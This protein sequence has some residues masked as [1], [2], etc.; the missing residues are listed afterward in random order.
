MLL[1]ETLLCLLLM[2]SHSQSK[3][4]R[5]FREFIT[6]NE[7]V[8]FKFNLREKTTTSN[9]WG[10]NWRWL[11]PWHNNDIHSHFPN[12]T[13]YKTKQKYNNGKSNGFFYSYESW[14]G[15]SLFKLTLHNTKIRPNNNWCIVKEN[16]L[17]LHLPPYCTP[18]FL[19]SLPH[20]VTEDLVFT[21]NRI[22]H[23]GLTPNKAENKDRIS[24]F[25]WP[26]L[27]LCN[28]VYLDKDPRLRPHTP[29]RMNHCPVHEPAWFSHEAL[30]TRQRYTLQWKKT[31]R[32][33]CK[34]W[35]LSIQ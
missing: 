27:L 3:K 28:V 21:Y 12:L 29:F 24:N 10:R 13:K 4:E 14:M 35:F 6:A 1:E 26:W 33:N 32:A 18:F 23:R 25:Y 5:E 22:S 8:L 17:S 11:Q 34:R 7:G 19:T 31:E 9:D 30:P 15:G 20:K 2:H 16:L